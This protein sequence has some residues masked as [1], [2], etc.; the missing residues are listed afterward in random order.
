MNAEECRTLAA[1]ARVAR[2][3]TLDPDGAPNLVPFV[4]ALDDDRLYTVVDRKP[5][6]TMA[7]ARLANIRRDPRV[8]VL[9]D[10]YDEDWS[11]LWWVKASGEARVV[12]DAT[13]IV[14]RLRAKYAQYEMLATENIG[15]I[16]DVQR[17]SGWR[18]TPS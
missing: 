17:W 10:H 4:F 7:L 6:R 11:A 13:E 5:K 15:I 12:D 9:F 18:M 16:I 2:L 3:A 8:T 14:E 1:T